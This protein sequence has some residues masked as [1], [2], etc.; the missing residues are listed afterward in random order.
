M[1]IIA[2]LSYS[3][4]PCA[5]PAWRKMCSNLLSTAHSVFSDNALS[6][7]WVTQKYIIK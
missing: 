4:I 1:D 2:I 6:Y 3:K 7:D 5:I